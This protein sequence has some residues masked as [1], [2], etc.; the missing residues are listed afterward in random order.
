MKSFSIVS[1]NISEKKGTV[2]IPVNKIELVTSTGIISDSHNGTWHRQVSLLAIED[3]DTMRERGFDVNPGDFAENITTRGIDLA[4]LPVGSLISIDDSLLEVTQI[5]KECHT[6]CEI[7]KSTGSCIMPKR[8]IFARVIK[9]G[10]VQPSSKGSVYEYENES[11]FNLNVSGYNKMILSELYREVYTTIA[12]TIIKTTCVTEGYA[13][14][15]GGGPGPLGMAL[16]ELTNLTVT[17]YDPLH[18]CLTAARDNSI[19]RNISNRIHVLE[20]SA[21]SIICKDST[22][23]LVVSRG[24]IFFWSNRAK[25]LQEVYRVLKPGGWAYIGGGFGSEE[26]KNK[27]MLQ[28]NGMDTKL[29]N[30]TTRMGSHRDYFEFLLKALSIDATVEAGRGGMWIVFT[31]K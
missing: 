30:R 19:R 24:S 18:E 12:R 6:G 21:E 11:S 9:N 1:V 31:K 29:Q 8:G 20:G 16:A 13:L 27:I 22:F 15:V 14:D 28:N 3:I 26:L 2:K 25:G 4:A 10:I 7:M 23:D 17:I 5:G